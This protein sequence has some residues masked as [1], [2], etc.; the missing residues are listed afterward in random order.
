MILA[1]GF[2]DLILII[3]VCDIGIMI[4]MTLHS[5][6]ILSSFYD[7]FELAYDMIDTEKN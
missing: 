7:I 4:C 3:G 2:M 1:L 5:C 6:V